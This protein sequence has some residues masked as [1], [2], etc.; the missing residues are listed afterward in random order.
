[1]PTTKTEYKY[2]KTRDVE[3]GTK[4]DVRFRNP[5]DWE[6]YICKSFDKKEQALVFVLKHFP[7]ETAKALQLSQTNEDESSECEEVMNHPGQMYKHVRW[8][9]IHCMWLVQLRSL[10]GEV[11]YFHDEEEAAAFVANSLGTTKAKL[12]KDERTRHY[13]NKDVLREQAAD[14]IEIMEDAIP[15]DA[16]NFEE[17]ADPCSGPTSAILAD[18]PGLIAGFC[19]GKH[20]HDRDVLEKI[21]KIW[22]KKTI[23]APAHMPGV[24][25][26][27]YRVYCVLMEAARR[28]SGSRWS[29]PWREHVG[30]GCDHYQRLCF[31]LIRVGILAYKASEPILETFT[32]HDSNVKYFPVPYDKHIQKKLLHTIEFGKALQQAAAPDNVHDWGN[33][34]RDIDQKT[35][36]VAGCSGKGNYM[37]LWIIRAFLLYRM[38]QRKIKKLK[39]GNATM[40]SMMLA[41]PDQKG[42]LELYASLPGI[43]NDQLSSVKVVDMVK[44]MRYKGGLEYLTM[45]GCLT[46]D[47]K[48]RKFLQRKPRG[49]LK[50]NRDHLRCV[51]KKFRAK[52]HQN[53][54]PACVV[55]DKFL[56]L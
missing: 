41:F 46:A 40:Q 31:Y 23:T 20:S 34:V 24:E 4:F 54:H 10:N 6:K 45:W 21:W 16:E 48:L 50:E 27:A 42:Q 13:G 55:L 29:V 43:R 39:P 25:I 8:H 38:R 19:L 14:L 56:C 18:A 51:R 28:L 3:G 15:A 17:Y 30:R 52:H 1:M 26:K 49:W 9:R 11:Y 53:P 5:K 36:T 12:K 44:A 2:I 37:K 35:G 22:A 7:E 33:T 32:Y 47:N